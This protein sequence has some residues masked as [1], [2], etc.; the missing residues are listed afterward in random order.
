M[1]QCEIILTAMLE[2]KNK[3][4]WTA[5]DFQSGKYF[6]GYEASA[7]M[8]DLMRLHPKVFVIEKIHRFRTLKINWEAEETKKLLKEYELNLRGK[9]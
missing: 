8:S 4:I 9:A 7:R 2:N 6:V 3:E 5:S 1:T